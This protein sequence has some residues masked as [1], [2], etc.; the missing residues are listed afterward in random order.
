MRL[1]ACYTVFNGLELLK[2]S[3]R[4]INDH[5][6]D[7]VICWQSISNK[8]NKSDEVR[9]FIENMMNEFNPKY[10]F[11][12]FT[13]N[14]NLST[15]ENEIIKHQMMIDAAKELNCTH[16]HLTA[17][18]HYYIPDEYARAKEIIEKNDYDCTVTNM[19]TYYKYPTWQLIPIEDYKAPFINKLYPNTRMSTGAFGAYVDPSVKVNTCKRFHCFSEQDIMLHHYSMVRDDVED[20]FKNAAASIGWKPGTVERLLKEYNNYDLAKNEGISYFQ[21]RK[22]KVVPNWFN[23]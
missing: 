8:G 9:E 13:P 6:D 1:A 21:G 23:I 18:D 17:T 7:I 16:F 22:I 4:S 5:V 12:K 11:K 3:I 2:H 20:K 19:Y 14:I 15:K 10:T